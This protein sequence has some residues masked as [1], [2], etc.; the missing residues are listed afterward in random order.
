MRKARAPHRPRRTTLPFLAARPPAADDSDAA[1]ARK[2]AAFDANLAKIHAVNG[3]EGGSWSAGVNQ[4]TDLTPA[5][6]RALTKGRSYASHGAPPALWLALISSSSRRGD[7]A[8][9]RR[10]AAGLGRARPL[11]ACARHAPPA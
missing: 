5:E 10:T 9:Q 7:S 4:F 11:C 1:S 3:R 8:C 6:F 2:A